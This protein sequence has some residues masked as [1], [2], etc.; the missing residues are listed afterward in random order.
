MGKLP[1]LDEMFILRQCSGI[2]CRECGGTLYIGSVSLE[3]ERPVF[4]CSDCDIRILIEL[5]TLAGE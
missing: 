4:F 3:D 5:K 2:E 1:I